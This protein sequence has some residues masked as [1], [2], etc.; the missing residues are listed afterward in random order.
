LIGFTMKTSTCW[1][2]LSTPQ[3]TLF[4]AASAT[5]LQGVWFDGQRHFNGPDPV[6]RRDDADPVLREAAAQL[7]AWY[8]GQ[9][10]SFDLPLAP[11]GTPFQQAVWAELRRIGHGC[12]RTYG[13]LAAALGRPSASRA[14]GAAT[15]RNPLSLVIPCHRLVG[16]TGALTGYAGG[17]DRKRA[18]LAFEAHAPGVPF[19]TA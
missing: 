6:W 8:A 16:S 13:E 12:T 11:I 4:L 19:E 17:L 7:R 5:G 14:V 3:G 9:R 18:L 1:T 15:G 10:R 2:T